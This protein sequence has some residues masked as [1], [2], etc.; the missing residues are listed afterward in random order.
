MVKKGDF[1]FF[2]GREKGDLSLYQTIYWIVGLGNN[3][4]IFKSGSKKENLLFSTY[5]S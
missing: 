2:F 5:S 3:N 1:Y 4:I